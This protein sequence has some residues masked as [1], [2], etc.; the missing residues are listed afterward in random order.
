M[1]IIL[2]ITQMEY[3]PAG[4]KKLLN[5]PN[6][7]INTYTYDAFGRLIDQVDGKGN[8]LIMKYDMM[9]R[10]TNNNLYI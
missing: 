7:G 8:H 2:F 1:R 3:D 5:E 4:N 6:A 10:I 9:G